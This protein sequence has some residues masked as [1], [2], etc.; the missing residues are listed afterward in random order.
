MTRR[1]KLLVPFYSNES[2][3]D[4]SNFEINSIKK[5][6]KEYDAE[7]IVLLHDWLNIDQM[8]SYLSIGDVVISPGNFIESF[9][10]IPLESIL[11]IGNFYLN[12]QQ[13]SQGVPE[14]EIINI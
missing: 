7:D 2:V 11:E 5:I 4:E 14:N 6:I 9:G 12:E 10:L 3:F 8:S 13:R 1:V